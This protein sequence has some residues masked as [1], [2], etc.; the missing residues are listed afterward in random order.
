VIK[1]GKSCASLGKRSRDAHGACGSL[2]KF[3][4]FKIKKNQSEEL[5]FMTQQRFL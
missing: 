2:I 5:K 4:V 3:A 1:D